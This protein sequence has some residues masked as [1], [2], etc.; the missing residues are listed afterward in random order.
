MKN[1]I[2]L[3]IGL[4]FAGI[5]TMQ[6]QQQQGFQRR[7]PDERAKMMVDRISDSLK[8]TTVQQKAVSDIFLDS[9]KA[10][11]KLREGLPEGT[12]PERADMEKISGERDIKLKGVLKE[13]QYNKFK[14]D[15]EPAMR[16]PRGD[17]PAGNN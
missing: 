11:D 2:I 5:F 14:N 16:R 9:Y 4:M 1:R 6:A 7:T 15:L 13:D 12:R 3:F 17:K 10:M 8:L